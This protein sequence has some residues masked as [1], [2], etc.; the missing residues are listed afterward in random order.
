METAGFYNVDGLYAKNTV[1][2][3]DFELNKETKGEAGGWK[4]FDSIEDASSELGF[5][6]HQQHEEGE[7]I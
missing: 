2:H 5:E 4:W 1:K 6:I 3:K 7:T